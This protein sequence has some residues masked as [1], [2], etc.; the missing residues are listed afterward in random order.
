MSAVRGLVCLQELEPEPAA[1][2][3]DD[4]GQS[5]FG[6]ETARNGDADERT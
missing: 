4:L 1:T 3:V 5:P 6:T 2:L